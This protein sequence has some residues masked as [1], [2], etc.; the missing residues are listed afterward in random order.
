MLGWAAGKGGVKRPGSRRR[1]P[2]HGRSAVGC[3]GARSL[4]V[5]RVGRGASVP[6]LGGRFGGLRPSEDGHGCLPLGQ[7]LNARSQGQNPVAGVCEFI[8]F[9]DAIGGSFLRHPD[10]YVFT[11]YFLHTP[12]CPMVGCRPLLGRILRNP[13]HASARDVPGRVA[14]RGPRRDVGHRRTSG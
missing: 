6:V 10:G 13:E 3:G 11:L 7:Q 5:C 4:G 1:R 14:V 8:I 12:I 2:E 9:L